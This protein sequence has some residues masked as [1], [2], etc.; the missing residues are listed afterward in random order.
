MKVMPSLVYTTDDV[1]PIV[2]TKYELFKLGERI[3]VTMKRRMLNVTT[4][5]MT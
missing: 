4:M 2:V 5:L 1:T 3:I